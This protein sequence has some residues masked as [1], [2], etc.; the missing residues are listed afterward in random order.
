MPLYSKAY[1]CSFFSFRA[2]YKAH[3]R[4]SKKR[5]SYLGEFGKIMIDNLVQE[6]GFPADCYEAI[7]LGMDAAQAILTDRVDAAIGIASFQ[8]IELEAAGKIDEMAQ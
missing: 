3:H 8:Q 5:I 1:T 4:Y 7:R 2:T 6:A